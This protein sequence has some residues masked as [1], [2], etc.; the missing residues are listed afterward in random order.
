MQTFTGRQYLQID[1]ANNFGLDKLEW[2][3][4]LGWFEDNETRLMSLVEK[5]DAPALMYAGIQAYEAGIRG[6]AVGYPVSFDATSSGIQILSCITGDRDAAQICNVVNHQGRADAYTIVY[7]RMME[8][9][10]GTAKIK[11]DDCKTAIMTAFY[12]SERQPKN[13]FGTGKQLEVFYQVMK[14]LAPGPWELNEALLSLWDKTKLSH[15]WV[16]P[17]NFH[18]H[19]KV[20]GKVEEKIQLFNEPISIFRK[21]NIPKEKGR[22]LSANTVHSIDGF[23]VREMTRRCD[24]D[25]SWIELVQ[26]L[27]SGDATFYFESKKQRTEAH[28]MVETLMGLYKRSGY[29]SARILDYIDSDT[30]VFL[31]PDLIQGMIDSM[32]RKPFKV[33]ATHDCFRALPRYMNEVRK[34][35]NLQLYLLAQSEMLS[36]LLEQIVDR[37]VEIEKLDPTLPKDIMETEYA[38]S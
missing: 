15:D 33:L 24:Y 11:R 16:M 27:L 35:Y 13:V 37:P 3:D 6:D 23:I 21:V 36:F 17:D 2:T 7:L 22:S 32:P 10:G 31:D 8:I 28:K 18:T 25:A 26:Q 30:I 20:M 19:I 9:L 14:E 29:L 1:I 34:Q 4:R 38:L 12:G 5:A